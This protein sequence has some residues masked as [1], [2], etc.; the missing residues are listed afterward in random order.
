VSGLGELVG[1]VDDVLMVALVAV[2]RE[3]AGA[4]V[5]TVEDHWAGGRK[6][7]SCSRSLG[8]AVVAARWWCGTAVMCG[9]GGCL[10]ILGWQLQQQCPQPT[11][12]AAPWN[13]HS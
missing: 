5:V 9:C 7:A 10:S 4:V 1:V 11:S 2:A 6:G 12:S 3:E 13:R 8:M